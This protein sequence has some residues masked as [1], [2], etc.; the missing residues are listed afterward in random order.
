MAALANFTP[1]DCKATLKSKKHHDYPQ[2]M[3]YLTVTV[4]HPQLGKI[5]DLQAVLIDRSAMPQGEFL[6]M[7]DDESDDLQKLALGVFDL[8]ANVKDSIV[9]DEHHR[10]TG[11]WGPELD[12][13]RILYIS[14]VQVDEPVCSLRTSL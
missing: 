2:S 11:C 1:A 9:Y 5:A 10:G 8:E 4:T 14:T 12:D 7:M 3:R 13:G 6:G